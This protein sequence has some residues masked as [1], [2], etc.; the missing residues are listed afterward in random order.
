MNHKKLFRLRREE[1]LAV[2]CRRSRK[3]ALGTGR[4]IPVPDPANQRWSLDFVSD[5]FEDG[6]NSRVLCNVDDCSRAALTTAVDRS[7]P[8]AHMTRELDELIRRSGQPDMFVSDNGTEMTSPALLRW[9]LHY[10]EGLRKRLVLVFP[11]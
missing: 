10:V 3:W 1:G 2:H 11:H 6:Q 7:R 9:F 8:R 4:A 5:A